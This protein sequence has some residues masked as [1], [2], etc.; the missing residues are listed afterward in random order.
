[1]NYIFI[2]KELLRISLPHYS[3]ASIL[4]KEEVFPELIGPFFT[5]ENLEKKALFLLEKENRERCLSLCDKLIHI[6]GRQKASEQ[7]ANHLLQAIND[8][9]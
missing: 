5:E 3:L 4:C 8:S 7:V 6:L 2:A 9:Y 1:M